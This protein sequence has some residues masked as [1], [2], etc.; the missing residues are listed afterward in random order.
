MSALKLVQILGKKDKAQTGIEVGSGV[1]VRLPTATFDLGVQMRKENGD[2]T[3][4][5]EENTIE[6]VKSCR[7]QPQAARRQV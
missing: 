2:S 4:G 1:L 6:D 7:T 5:S 3:T